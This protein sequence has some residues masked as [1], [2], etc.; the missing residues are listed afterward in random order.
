M[1]QNGFV[2]EERWTFNHSLQRTLIPIARVAQVVFVSLNSRTDHLKTS[3]RRILLPRGL[4]ALARPDLP[5]V[6]GQPHPGAVA[7]GC[8][9]GEAEHV[10]G[11]DP[12]GVVLI[13]DRVGDVLE[14]ALGGAVAHGLVPRRPDSLLGHTHARFLPRWHRGILVLICEKLVELESCGY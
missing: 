6:L 12:G 13:V 14:L 10:L 2:R 7:G 3:L 11:L 8:L 1:G 5:L 9:R 4:L